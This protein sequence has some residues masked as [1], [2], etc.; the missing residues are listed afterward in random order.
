MNY[1]IPDLGDDPFGT[2][3]MNPD[4]LIVNITTSLEV[5][6]APKNVRE[7]YLNSQPT[8]HTVNALGIWQVRFTYKYPNFRLPDLSTLDW[9]VL[10]S[11][12]E[13]SRRTTIHYE[14][15]QTSLQ[16][17][18]RATTPRLPLR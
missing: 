10:D 4:T 16:A 17:F 3:L 8:P 18:T 14:G 5:I 2:S 12:P 7:L 9:S 13:I 1:W 15:L 6:G 11:L